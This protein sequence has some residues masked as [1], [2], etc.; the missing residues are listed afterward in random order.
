MN[1]HHIKLNQL[2]A[3][4]IAGNNI[5]SSSLYVF[6]ITVFF[7][8]IYAPFV[9]AVIALVLYFYKAVYTE[10]V[11]ALPINGGA[12]NCLLNSTSKTIAAVAGVTTVLSYVATAVI[13]AKVA[14]GYLHT[15][16]AVPVIP[17]TIGLLL[18]FAVIVIIGIK[19][20]SRI[21]LVIFL[22]H[23]ICLTAFVVWGIAV[24]WQGSTV[25][26]EN[27]KN[28]ASLIQGHG[29]LLP[30]LFFG[31]SASLLGVSGFENSADFVEEQKKGVFR[32]TLRN[33]LIGVAI[34]NPLIAFVILG[35]SPLQDIIGAK[36]FLLA[37]E[38]N[39]IGGQLFQYIIV[40][41]A[42]LVL[43][44]AVLASYIGVSGLIYRMAA[45][46]CLPDFLTKR[47]KSGSSPRI[48]I[49]F[50]LLCTLILLITKGD[51]FSLAGVYAI[52]FLSVMSLFAF[53]NLILRE[54]RTELKRTYVAP[55]GFVLIAF[56]ATA[57][58]VIGNIRIDANNLIYFTLYFIPAMLLILTIVYQDYAIRFFLRL[59]R[60]I[61]KVH[62]YIA[63]Y[64]DDMTSGTFV[65]FI[66][67]T[68]NL[69]R[70]LNYI[71]K[72]E[73]GQNIVLVHCNND[74]SKEYS[75]SYHEIKEVLP[76][77]K[78]AGVFPHF[79]IKLIYKNEP[80]GAKVISEVSKELKV[81]KNRIL[82]GSIHDFHD[83]DYAS[84]GGVRII[85]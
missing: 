16:I 39:V 49:T 70:I 64:F 19:D 21:A 28:S 58:G 60:K 22:F 61:P 35:L 79:T 48:V 4:A 38:A 8:G 29:G 27:I 41:D 31:F 59:T 72:N 50:F 55:L 45:D 52:A 71:Y 42:F 5:L 53:G 40:A 77:L 75:Q 46:A 43:A 14:I 6:G 68:G 2:Y 18:F 83:F 63:E 57:G 62:Q 24:L 32:K 9:L 26:L 76:V 11:E 74:N 23:I 36:D 78:K 15:V 44:G 7:A 56:F 30:A 80:F 37:H 20:S 66:R 47:N 67:H 1:K 54:T 34:F 10:V 69:H 82:I 3:T 33:M 65:A 51:I 85:F 73:T 84:L 25:L 81:R 12:Y 17:F 13:S